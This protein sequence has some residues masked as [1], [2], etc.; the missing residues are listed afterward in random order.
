[1]KTYLNV[2]YAD[3]DIAKR[4]GAKWD[5]ARKLWFVENLDNLKPFLRWMPDNLRKPSGK[6]KTYVEG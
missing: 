4:L 2:P 6:V 5:L 3:K 1:M